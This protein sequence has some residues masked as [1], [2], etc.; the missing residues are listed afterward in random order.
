MFEPLFG[1]KEPYEH[2]K[3]LPILIAIN[4]YNRFIGRVDITD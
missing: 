4:D 3:D 1:C 2:T